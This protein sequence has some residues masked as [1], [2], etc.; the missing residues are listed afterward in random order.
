MTGEWW[1]VKDVKGRSRCLIEMLPRLL[2]E[3]AE[4]NLKVSE[5]QLYVP[6]F[7]LVTLWIQ[8]LCITAVSACFVLNMDL[9]KL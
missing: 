5:K 9:A 6:R 2:P 8:F 4:E 3:R 7:E 1:Y